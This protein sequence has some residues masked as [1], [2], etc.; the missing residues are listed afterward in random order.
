M[1][2]MEAA[3]EILAGMSLRNNGSAIGWSKSLESDLNRSR[4]MESLIIRLYASARKEIP[5]DDALEIEVR[6]AMEDLK[7]IPDSDLGAAF[8]EAQ[9]QSGGFIPTNG[10]IVKVW[11]GSGVK[12]FDDAQKAIR[13]RNT[14]YYLGWDKANLPSPE[15][16]EANAQ[17]A[18]EIA[19]KLAGQA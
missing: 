6:L 13:D 3:G 2:K 5:P 11:R 14:A 16:R 4:A 10:L 17:A 19:R 18:A 15:E 7:E 8:M 12:N 1:G 9:V